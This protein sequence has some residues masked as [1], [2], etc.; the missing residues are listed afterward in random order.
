M[1]LLYER[2]LV[3]SKVTMLPGIDDND[4]AKGKAQGNVFKEVLSVH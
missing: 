2:M 1:W 3:Q 4:M